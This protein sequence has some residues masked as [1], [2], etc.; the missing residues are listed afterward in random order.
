MMLQQDHPDDYVIATGVSHSV[1]ELR[2]D[3]LRPRRARLAEIC[4]ASIRRCCGR[5]KSIICWA[6]RRR[7]APSWAGTPSVDFK[8]LVEMMV[9]ADLELIGS[10]PRAARVPAR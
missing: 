1:R 10:A 9:D 3:R 2:R 8:Q 7:R 4:R 5:P 6:I